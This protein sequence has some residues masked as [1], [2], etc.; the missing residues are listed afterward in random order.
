MENN[1]KVMW[2]QGKPVVNGWLAIP[3][4]FSAELMAGQGWDSLT[5]DMQH[6]MVGYDTLLPMLAAISPTAPPMARV[7]WLE[8]GIIMKSLDAGCLGIICPMV[9]SGDDAEAFIQAMRYP[10]RGGR[11]FGPTRA[12]LRY[13]SDYAKHANDQCIAMAMIETSAALDNIDDIMATDNLDAI[14][15]GPADLSN[16]L[17]YTPKLDQ[18]E[19]EVV[20]AIDMILAKAKEHG[21]RAG[22]HNGSAAYAQRMV[23]KGFDLVTIMSDARLLSKACQT[24]LA[25]FHDTKPDSVEGVY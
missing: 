2:E 4:F 25:A 24:E 19:P 3:S 17:G 9:N 13:G 14:Y 15:I 21:L 16:S 22:I 23:A 12:I 11:S 10:P 1:I 6:G 5:V 20:E 7:P 8:P 18:E